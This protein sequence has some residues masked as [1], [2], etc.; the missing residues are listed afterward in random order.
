MHP[1]STPHSGLSMHTS[2]G[3]HHTADTPCPCSHT[4]LPCSVLSKPKD[5]RQTWN[6]R[7]GGTK[8]TIPQ[9]QV[10]PPPSSCLSGSSLW[11]SEHL[12]WTD[13]Q[14]Q[15]PTPSLDANPTTGVSALQ[16][17]SSWAPLDLGVLPAG[18]NRGLSGPLSAGDPTWVHSIQQRV[19][20]PQCRGCSCGGDQASCLEEI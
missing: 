7:N 16:V 8:V 2:K 19:T 5:C 10:T 14:R 17:L 13:R 18:L 12:G 11:H 15:P 4:S 9:Y 20:S 6:S 1:K 3:P